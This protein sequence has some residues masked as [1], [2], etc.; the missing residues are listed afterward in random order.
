MI[1][2]IVR[3]FQ[4]VPLP[5]QDLVTA[6]VVFMD[7]IAV[8][9]LSRASA[10]CHAKDASRILIVRVDKIG[11][12]VLWTGA[13]KALRTHFRD[14]TLC[15]VG[16]ADWI[17]WARALHLADEYVPVDRNRF[18]LNMLYRWKLIA[19]LRHT[20]CPVAIH[21]TYSREILLG[22]S[23]VRFSGAGMRIGSTGDSSNTLAF[24]K[25]LS[26]HWYT[27][28]VPSASE[29]LMELVR[30][31]EFVRGLG[32]QE[33]VAER[34]EL[35]GPAA[36]SLQTS[37]PKTANF[38]VIFP[39][40]SN[41]GRMWPA[42]NFIALGKRIRAATGWDCRI[43][44][45]RSE[46]ALGDAISKGLAD[47]TANLCGTTS[48]LELAEII[49][50]ARLVVSNETSAIHIAAGMNTPSVCI[51][52]GGHFGRFLPYKVERCRNADTLPKVVAHP[53]SCFGCN[54]KC[55]YSTAGD[56]AFP[57]VSQIQVDA[58]WENVKPLLALP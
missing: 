7:P 20:Q 39:G 46:R 27:R 24:L 54:W 33:F 3:W 49:D 14:K 47:S 28:L 51:T 45:S 36:P 50:S 32:L 42:A 11:D 48:I 57:C 40:G 53:M 25:S 1:R 43:C 37:N 5:L 12:F 16:N 23:L 9:W 38:F 29:P 35:G 13:A 8:R 15:L 44:G 6:L 21:P 2:S 18:R 22:D 58:V 56:E 34:A 41:P 4:R 26:D 19:G 31:A 30:N 55:I 52:G 10:K 17:E